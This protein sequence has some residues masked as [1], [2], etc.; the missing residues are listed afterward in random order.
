[1][2][3]QNPALHANTNAHVCL[4]AHCLPRQMPPSFRLPCTFDWPTPPQ[5]VMAN[6]RLGEEN[7]GGQSR[8]LPLPFL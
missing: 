6:F 1:M 7:K 3:L 4:T 8:L 2:S 5:K